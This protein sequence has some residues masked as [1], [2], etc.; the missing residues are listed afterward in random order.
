[1][2]DTSAL[3]ALLAAT[4]ALAAGATALTRPRMA[5]AIL[6]LLASFSRATLE[7]PIGTMRPEMPAIA[8]VA[9]IL[10]ARGRFSTLRTLP[11]PTVAMA[12]AFAIFLGVL[13]FS[14]AFIAPGRDQSLR[15]VAWFATSMLGGAVAFVLVRPR[16]VESIEPMAF[17][18]AVMGAAGILAAVMFLVAGPA[19][20]LGIQEPVVNPRVYALGWE[21][22]LYASFLGM[23]ALFALEAARHINRAVGIAGLALVLTGFALGLTR[24]AYV[25]LAAGLIAYVGVRL[26]VERRWG[27]LP[28]LGA[29]AAVLLIGGFASAAVLLPNSVQRE[30]G[31]VLGLRPSVNPGPPASF[32]PRSAPPSS[33]SGVSSA[34]VP[35]ASAVP[36]SS[37]PAGSSSSPATPIPTFGTYPDTLAFRLERVP[38]A[39]NDLRSSPLVGFGAE[40]FGQRHPERYAGPGPDHIAIMAIVVP[41]ESGVIG[42]A[43][44]AIGFALLLIALWKTAHRASQDR[45]WRG[46][47]A[48]AAFIGA[49]VSILVAYQVTNALQFAINW[50][51]IGAAAALTAR[52]PSYRAPEPKGATA[53]P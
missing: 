22:N 7:T 47:G 1:M 46:V 3:V 30:S 9:A 26:W 19:F 44:L 52:E 27:D 2:P 14:S 28:R 12:I 50:I 41:Y 5:F 11:R 42:A 24:G 39:L 6:F 38:I 17:A 20:D 10:L 8:V 51:V 31:G 45:D 37:T 21:T 53:W 25:G 49:V 15:M 33:S 36:G 35:A 18:G 40:S 16:P 43:A 13:T 34:T 48:A 29:I 23:C 4:G 32:A